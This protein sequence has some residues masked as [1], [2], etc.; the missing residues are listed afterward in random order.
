MKSRSPHRLILVIF[1][2][3]AN[4]VLYSGFSN[5]RGLS[6]DR[7]AV[8]GALVAFLVTALVSY[9]FKSLLEE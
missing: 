9:I 6:A 8:L 1:A 7:A 3:T 4:F 2:L 5:V